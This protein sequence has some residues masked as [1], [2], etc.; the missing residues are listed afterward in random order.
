MGYFMNRANLSARQTSFRLGFSEQFMKRIFNKTVELKVNTFLEFLDLVE[1]T[2][3]D[4][5]YLGKEFSE[6]DKNM[7]DMFNKL[8]KEGK[9]AIVSIMKQIK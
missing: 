2:P 8:S 4:F 6:E 5:F 3:Q 9:A 1:I 7:L